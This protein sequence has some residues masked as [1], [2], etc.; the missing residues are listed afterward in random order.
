MREMVGSEGVCPLKHVLF[1]HRSEAFSPLALGVQHFDLSK[2]L[3]GVAHKPAG[4]PRNPHVSAHFKPLLEKQERNEGSRE[5]KGNL[6]SLGG[7][8]SI[9][10][11]KRHT[12][13]NLVKKSQRLLVEPSALQLPPHVLSGSH[14]HLVQ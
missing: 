10:K 4:C 14:T 2:C 9:F 1:P 11:N 3:A 5:E 6:R 13:Q 7:H 8:R 12:P